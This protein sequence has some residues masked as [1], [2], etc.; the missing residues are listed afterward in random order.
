MLSRMYGWD[1]A[2]IGNTNICSEESGKKI[3]RFV[4]GYH[5]CSNCTSENNALYLRLFIGM[6]KLIYSVGILL[7]FVTGCG[8][9]SDFSRYTVIELYRQRIPGSKTIIYQ[10]TLTGNITGSIYE[11]MSVLDSSETFAKDD[12]DELPCSYFSAIPGK[13]SLKMLEINCN[14]N[15]STESDTLLI[16]VRQ[17]STDVR[18]IK[19]DVAEYKCTYGSS[20]ST[21]LMSYRFDSFKETADSLIFYNVIGK[22][23]DTKFPSVTSFPKG[24][25]KIIDSD[26]KDIIFIHI[27]NAV[28]GR[29]G[30]FLPRSTELLNDRPVVGFATYEFYP[31]SPIKS[32]LLSDYGF[33][34]RVR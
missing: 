30:V 10:F 8:S 14:L 25:I 13:D 17:Y 7:F 34:K 1:S 4:N 29:K 16:P 15:P 18:R 3:C 21:Y 31:T 12:V 22:P 27:E 5:S 28:I 24:N 19:I 11:G 32:S 9:S 26:K 2:L 33:F 23:D 6:R 20:P